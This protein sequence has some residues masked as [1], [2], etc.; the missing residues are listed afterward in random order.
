MKLN[1]GSGPKQFYFVMLGGLA[2]II[3]LGGFAYVK[4]ISGLN[5][6]SQSLRKDLAEIKLSTERNDSLRLL[7]TS[8]DNVVPVLPLIEKAL[9]KTKKQTEIILQLK[10]IASESGMSI[11]GFI[12]AVSEKLPNATSQTTPAPPV[13][14]LPIEVQLNG[15]YTQMQ[16]FLQK[17]ENLD[18]YNN[19]KVLTINR[20]DPKGASLT[21]S[22]SLNAYLQP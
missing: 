14:A 3:A 9:P 1:M 17:L 18:R 21:F 8:Y 15:S 20:S 7:K 6:Q 16:G 19:V 2:A 11:P 13:A 22:I 5:S 4:A 12:F 10:Q